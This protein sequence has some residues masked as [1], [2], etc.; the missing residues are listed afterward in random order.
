MTSF[1]IKLPRRIAGRVKRDFGRIRQY[2]MM[3]RLKGIIHVGA[4]VAQECRYYER[5]HLNVLWIEPNPEM[6]DQLKI[7]L[8]P[9]PRQR[10]LQYLV[11]DEDKKKSTLHIANNRGF[12]SSVL[13]LAQIRDIWPSI[14]FTRDIEMPAYRLDTII[15]KEAI[16]LSNY[17]GLVLDTEGSELLVLKGA[18]SVLQGMKMV[19]VEV[20]DFEVYSGCPR[21]EHIAEIL[22]EY[23]LHEWR[24]VPFT[25]QH[26][27]GGNIYD[28]TYLR[29]RTGHQ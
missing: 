22:K 29:G 4:N 26:P 16:D 12:S 5:F 19:K 14:E 2:L 17:D 25:V 3:K 11:L 21:P 8:A 23:N 15:A 27:D 6:F 18:H 24:R 20:A 9:Y 7:I 28:I 10:P 1:S 13:S